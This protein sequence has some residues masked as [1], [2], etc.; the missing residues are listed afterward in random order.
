MTDG[1]TPREAFEA[2]TYQALCA[3]MTATMALW[4]IHR[5]LQIENAGGGVDWSEIEGNMW[6]ANEAV[7][8][9]QTY[10]TDEYGVVAQYRRLF[11]LADD[12]VTQF[13]ETGDKEAHNS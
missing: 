4:E 5:S 13:P 8:F 9:A 2:Q 7:G 3:S 12:E 10:T 6:E 11:D 1:L